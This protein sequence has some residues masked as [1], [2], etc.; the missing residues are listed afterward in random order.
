MLTGLDI[1]FKK[2]YYITTSIRHPEIISIPAKWFRNL[3]RTQFWY[4]FD[5]MEIFLKGS[6]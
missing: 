4:Q 3:F 2:Y 1:C 5:I 6:E